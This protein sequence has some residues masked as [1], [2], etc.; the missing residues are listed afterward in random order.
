MEDCRLG[1]CKPKIQRKQEIKTVQKSVRQ[2]KNIQ[3]LYFEKNYQPPGELLI[4]SEV[5]F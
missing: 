3:E 1:H 5:I 4:A 2:L